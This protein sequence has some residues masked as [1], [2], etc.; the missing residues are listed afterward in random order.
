MSFRRAHPVTMR[1]IYI[2]K[3]GI[4][5]YKNIVT[6]YSYSSFCQKVTSSHY[7]NFSIK[8]TSSHYFVTFNNFRFFSAIFF[9]KVFKQESAI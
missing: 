8:I 1:N 5:R 7:S 6:H 4:G 2:Y 3:Q 9:K